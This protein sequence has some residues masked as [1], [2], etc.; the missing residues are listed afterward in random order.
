MEEEQ[1]LKRLWLRIPPNIRHKSKTGNTF[2]VLSQKNDDQWKLKEKLLKVETGSK[3]N[4]YP[5]ILFHHLT[6]I[7]SMCLEQGLQQNC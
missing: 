3:Y 4:F 5:N 7:F 1:S 2:W 6:A